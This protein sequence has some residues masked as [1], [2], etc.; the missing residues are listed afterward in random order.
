MT[1]RVRTV[2]V[3]F[4]DVVGSTEL[5]TAMGPD[6]EDHR[7]RHFASLRGALALHSGR[8]VKTLGDGLMAVFDSASDALAC[9]ATM[10][11]ASA[12]H[13]DHPDHSVPIRIGL[14]AGDTT[15]RDSDY[16]GNVVV[17]ASRLCAHADGGQILVSDAVRRIA[18]PVA[19]PELRHLGAIELKG[20]PAPVQVHELRWATDAVSALR[21]ALVDDAVLL[22]EGIAGL[23][24]A[25]GFEIVLE[26]GDA[27]TL[28]AR[29]DAARPHV[30]IVDVRMPPSFT[31]EGLEAARHIRDT[32]PD[33][34]VLVLTQS[35]EYVSARQLLAGETGGGVGYLLKERVGDPREL[36]DAIRT[37]ARGGRVLDPEVDCSYAVDAGGRAARR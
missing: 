19:D 10:Q 30:V 23:L 11:R 36:A 24:R 28:L 8:E 1:T 16:Q 5:F 26:A 29:L 25:E 31:T 14:S 9:A 18:A 13:V 27:E 20:L 12:T 4:T 33:V 37:I 3:A 34:G 32:R 21:V 7:A 15:V 22:R 6:A 2:T 35:L 17:E